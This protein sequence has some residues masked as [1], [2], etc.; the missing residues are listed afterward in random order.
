MSSINKPL[1]SIIIPTYNEERD[2]EN[3]MDSLKSQSYKPLE[4]IVVDDGSK[5]KTIK[6]LKKIK[7]V[8][9]VKQDHLGPGAARNKG[10]KFAKGKILVFV[11]ADMTFDRE[12][13]S[14]LTKPILEGTDIGTFTKEELIANPQNKWSRYWSLD[15]G[16]KEGRMHPENYPDSQKVFRA[17]LTDKFR[18]AGG[19]D[20]S[21]GYTDD[22][23]LSSKLG[24]KANSAS[25]AIIY[26]R[27]PDSLK[28]AF[29]QA[30]WMA[31]RPYKLKLIG[32]TF[33]LLRATFPISL[34]IGIFKSIRFRSPTFLIFKLSI[35]L[36][37]FIGVS[38]MFFSKDYAK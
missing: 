34:V 32:K 2:I 22:W 30:K 27:N 31:K 24:E 18:Q 6:I 1:I 10:S 17:I 4:I 26:H 33:A 13:I 25:G 15:R 9:L 8:R 28:E 19:F 16:F 5:D 3:C 20:I 29:T 12:F 11:D 7:G 35:D 37:S 14:K 38:S 23:T 21:V 36:A